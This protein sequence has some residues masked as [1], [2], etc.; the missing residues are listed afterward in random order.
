MQGREGNEDGM[1]ME[2]EDMSRSRPDTF[3]SHTQMQ[4]QF[5]ARECNMHTASLK[6]RKTLN[7]YATKQPRWRAHQTHGCIQFDLV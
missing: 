3:C 5:Y 2:N 4:Q 6:C 7:Q 1:E